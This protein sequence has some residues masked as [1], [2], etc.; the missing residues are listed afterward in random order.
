MAEVILGGAIGGLL[1]SFL[2]VVAL[3]PAKKEVWEDE[4]PIGNQLGPDVPPADPFP[5]GVPGVPASAIH[6]GSGP[7]DFRRAAA[8]PGC[9]ALA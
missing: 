4:L 7:H 6:P 8:L 3:T 1:V 5:A 9:P 2:A